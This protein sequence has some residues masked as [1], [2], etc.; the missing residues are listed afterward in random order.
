[1]RMRVS[2]PSQ[3]SRIGCS[4]AVA[5]DAV[6]APALAA[7][8]PAFPLVAVVAGEL[9]PGPAGRDSIAAEAILV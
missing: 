5:A 1:M 4:M 3:G 7:S 6:V 8:L 2:R 9:L